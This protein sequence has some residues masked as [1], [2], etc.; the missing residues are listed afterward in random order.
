MTAFGMLAQIDPVKEIASHTLFTFTMFGY[1]IEFSNHMLMIFVSAVLLC[2]AIPLSIRKGGLVRT[3]FGNFIEGVCVFIR[4]EMA[5]PF[6]HEKTDR[7][8]G[9]LWTL[10]FF[11]VTLNLLG[12]VPFEKIFNLLS[13][14]VGIKAEHI[15]GAA[16]ANIWVTGAL[17]II[18]LFMIH[19]S[20]MKEQGVR[21]YIRNFAPPVPLVLKPFV[22][23]IEVLS[24]LIKPFAL[25]IRLFA[26]IFAGHVLLSVI[27]GFTVIFKNYAVAGPSILFA[28]VM[29]FIEIFVAVL[30]AYI[31]TYLTAIFI[32]FSIAGE[33]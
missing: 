19:F 23:L 10:F 31:F 25:A 17:A 29:S 21:G 27:I 6:L 2:I 9:F 5:R 11:I 15:G 28:V 3:G 8:I 14:T 18:S 7:Y 12:L 30:Q 22:F 16:T 20:G 1:K 4:E 26:N 24:T 13:I 33:H 32:S